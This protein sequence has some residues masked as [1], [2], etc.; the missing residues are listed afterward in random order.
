MGKQGEIEYVGR[1][2][3]AEL[4]HA[5]N[6]P[7]SDSACDVYPMELGAIMALLPPPP[8]HL[9]DVGCGTGW[10][11]LFFARRGYQ[12]L[13]IDIAPDMIEQA[14]A[15]RQ[16][17]GVTGATFRVAD[18]ET[19]N[20]DVDFDCAVFFDSLHHAIDERLALRMVHQALRP[21]GVCVTSEPGTGHAASD[22]ARTARETYSVTEKDMP[23]RHIVALA[24]EA[25]FSNFRTF[26]HAHQVK[27]AVY[28]DQAGRLL[29]AWGRRFDCLR[30]LATVVSTANIRF[31]G[32]WDN[33]IVVMV[34]PQSCLSRPK[35][36]DAA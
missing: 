10:T 11:S 36:A 25:G 5:V 7:F 34:K 8:A 14:E 21:G 3:E 16:R 13:G 6:K 27:W 2:T 20:F 30:R 22:V 19:V 29:G 12:V 17:G 4:R 15:L 1:L 9:L 23:P 35:S 31:R 32:E 24:K 26:P 18:Y 28:S 33:A